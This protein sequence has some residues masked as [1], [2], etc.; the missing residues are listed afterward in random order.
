MQLAEEENVYMIGARNNHV[1]VL[2]EGESNVKYRLAINIKSSVAP[3][4]YQ[5]TQ[6]IRYSIMSER[7]SS[8]KR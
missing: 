1:E 2:V 5:E 6:Q 4:I 8:R 3:E 7:I